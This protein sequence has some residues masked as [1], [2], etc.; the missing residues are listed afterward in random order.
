MHD[1]LGIL[2]YA[3]RWLSH[4]IEH[5]VQSCFEED[6]FYHVMKFS[7]SYMF[8]KCSFHGREYCFCHPP[9]P[10][11][12]AAL[13]SFEVCLLSYHRHISSM[14]VRRILCTW[15]CCGDDSPCIS[16]CDICNI[17]TIVA[18]HNRYYY[19]RVRV[20]DISSILLK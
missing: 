6:L 3:N 7:S 18:E 13:P 15:A 8:T 2:V 20:F 10:I 17:D 11:A 12:H 19:N 1:S 4:S 5:I 14:T 16:T 9:V